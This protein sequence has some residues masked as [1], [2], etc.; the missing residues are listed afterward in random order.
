VSAAY[1]VE[2]ARNRSGVEAT[3]PWLCPNLDASDR[4]ALA[5][6]CD[7]IRTVSAGTELLR[8]DAPTNTLHILLDGWAA[9]YKIMEDGGRFIPT[10]AVPG[11]V[12][13]LDALRF[14]RLDYGVMMVSAGVVA[15]LPRE[16][17]DALFATNPAV[18]DAFWSLALAENSILMEWGASV[19]RRCAS[20]RIAHLLCDLLVRLTVVGKAH[21]HSYDLPLT[22]EHIA[23]ALGL[24]NV[25]VNRTMQ[26]LRSNQLVTVQH[27]RVTIHNWTAL[28]ASCGFRPDYLHLETVGD[29]FMPELPASGA[30]RRGPFARA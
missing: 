1:A 23:D 9:R 4:A 5:R 11:D 17:A 10:L 29:E 2:N 24:T 18:A 20:Q 13:D 16:R 19:G 7:D 21:G 25:H 28:S 6:A 3:R 14:S 26:S 27:R 15:V 22:Q 12:C 30:R 8:R